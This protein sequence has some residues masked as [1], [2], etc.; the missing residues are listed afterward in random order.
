MVKQSDKDAAIMSLQRN[1]QV[2]PNDLIE[3]AR[4]PAHPCH[5]DFTW[6]DTQAAKERRRDQ[7]RAAIR[8]CKFELLADEVI[9]RVVSYVPSPGND[10]NTFTAIAKVR[11]KSNVAAMMVTELTMLHGNVC[12]AYGLALAKRGMVGDHVSE[13]LGDMREQVAAL[14]AEVEG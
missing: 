1:G 12:R 13:Q 4:V 5:G 6:D 2:D 9:E 7:A 11:S 8:K 3:A 10:G 14:K